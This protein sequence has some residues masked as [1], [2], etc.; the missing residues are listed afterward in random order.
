M[1]SDPGILPITKDI[2]KKQNNNDV[3]CNTC[4]IYANNE[5]ALYHCMICGICISHSEYHCAWIGKCIG[6]NNSNC[7]KIFLLCVVFYLL[8]AIDIYFFIQT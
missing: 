2:Y 3:Y 8:L 1:I 5:D 6:K 4:N 7:Y